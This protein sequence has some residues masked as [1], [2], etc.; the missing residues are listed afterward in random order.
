MVESTDAGTVSSP[1]AGA[2]SRAM[3]SGTHPPE[4]G[5]V[6]RAGPA[7]LDE[8]ASVLTEAFADDAP[9]GWVF[10]DPETYQR[11]APAY[12][13][14][15][16]RTVLDAGIVYWVEGKGATLFLPSS[17]L[18]STP[19]QLLAA[20]RELAALGAD[21]APQLLAYR[22]AFR[23]HHPMHTPHWY[24][25]LLA[26]RPAHQRESVGRNLIQQAVTELGDLPHYCDATP[27]NAIFPRQFGYAPTGAFDVNSDIRFI[28]MWREPAGHR[29]L[30]TQVSHADNLPI[31]L[32][33]PFLLSGGP[34]VASEAG[35]AQ[36][37][38]DPV[39]S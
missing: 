35:P 20:R 36:P 11:L 25:W 24:C 5:P 12:F 21:R 2:S 6:R 7:D 37:D 4:P 28:Q 33:T 10:G 14:W 18:E 16:T 30:E 29:P 38:D 3:T 13:R 26:V 23:R 34:G 27:D 39:G 15:V 32:S 19:Q 31:R 9:L 22:D 17:A 1:G 8:V